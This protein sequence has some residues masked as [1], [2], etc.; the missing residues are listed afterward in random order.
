MTCPERGRRPSSSSPSIQGPLPENARRLP[1]AYA[2]AAPRRRVSEIAGARMPGQ[3]REHVAASATSHH[4]DS[5][6]SSRRSYSPSRIYLS[7][8]LG[9]RALESRRDPG[10]VAFP[11]TAVAKDR[12]HRVGATKDHVPEPGGIKRPIAAESRIMVRRLA[13]SS[14]RRPP[15]READMSSCRL[16]WHDGPV[17]PTGTSPI[18]KI[19][20]R[21]LTPIVLSQGNT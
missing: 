21:E 4:K 1:S 15:A 5:S 6:R 20:P 19:R 9:L 2:R 13:P 7:P 14:I 17:S 11:R 16:G 10:L 8:Q 18:V 12:D 3:Q